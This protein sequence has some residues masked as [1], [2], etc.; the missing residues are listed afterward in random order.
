MTTQNSIHHFFKSPS[1]GVVGASNDRSKFGNKVLRKYLEHQLVAYP[2]NPHE[3]QVEGIQCFKSVKDLP[4][5]TKSISI[6]TPP[7]I[8]EEIVQEAIEKGIQNIWM[9]SG[10]ESPHAIEL[11]Q[12]AGMSII[13]DGACILLVLG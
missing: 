7:S 10:A 11:C 1:F 9:Q 2:V 12:K 3:A 6:I 8:T 4:T 13:A 5:D